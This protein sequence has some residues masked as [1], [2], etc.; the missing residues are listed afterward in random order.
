[1]TDEPNW[2][3]R[4]HAGRAYHLD[5]IM[6]ACVRYDL[7]ARRQ[8]I[9]TGHPDLT[10][11]GGDMPMEW[12]DFDEGA[13]YPGYTLVIPGIAIHHLAGMESNLEQ[14]ETLVEFLGDLRSDIDAIYALAKR[15]DGAL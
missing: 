2:I 14:T 5:G 13:T 4:T 6:V 8:Q 12:V 3:Y 7:E 11:F 10:G 15:Q 9:L 1:M